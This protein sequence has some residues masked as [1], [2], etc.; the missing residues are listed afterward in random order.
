MLADDD[1]EAY[2]LLDTHA[3]LLHAA[4]AHHYHL[5]DDG[6]RSFNFEAALKALREAIGTSA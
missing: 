1:A 6:I 5:I 4:F 3:E 2:D